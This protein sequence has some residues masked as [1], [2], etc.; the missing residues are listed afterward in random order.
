M[1]SFIFSLILASQLHLNFIS[2][3]SFQERPQNYNVFVMI[4]TFQKFLMNDYFFSKKKLKV[5]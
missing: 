3:S 2:P 4:P 5:V 1:I